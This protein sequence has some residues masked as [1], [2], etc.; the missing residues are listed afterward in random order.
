MKITGEIS[1]ETG[2]QAEENALLSELGQTETETS[3]QEE[4]SL[5]DQISADSLMGRFTST[6]HW[7][8][9]LKRIHCSVYFSPM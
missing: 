2:S 7:M 1:G 4:L 8:L 9:L 3:G 6:C 5:L